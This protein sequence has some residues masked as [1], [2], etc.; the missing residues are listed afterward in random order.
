MRRTTIAAL[1]T[2]LALAGALIAP[3]G[4]VA[5]APAKVV[6]IVG[7]VGSVTASYKSDAD[8]IAAAALKYTPDVV[9]IYT[10]NATWDVVKA[11]LQGANVVV[12][13]GHGNGFPS[14]YRTSPW[15][16][17]QD[18]V[19]LNPAAG[20]GDTSV[21]YYGESYLANEVRLAPN[22]F[23][24]LVHLCYASGN[25]EP[26]RGD[27]TLA[28]AQQRIDNYGAG[29][30]AAG[31]RAVVAD[32]HYGSS[33]YMDALFTTGQTI[34]AV[35]RGAP[36]ARGNYGSFASTRTPGALAEYDPDTPTTG[37]YRSF[38]GDPTLTTAAVTGGTP[39]SLPAPFSAPS[40]PVVLPN[41]PTSGGG[42]ATQP[43][44]P[45]P[46]AP[47]PT[48]RPT[49]PAP[50]VPPVPGPASTPAVPRPFAVSITSPTMNNRAIVWGQSYIDIATTGTPGTNFRLE[51]ST[52]NQTW[53]PLKDPNGGVLTW[54]LDGTGSS[55]Y[56]YTPIRNYWYRA[57]AGGAVTDVART[58][59]RE[60]TTLLPS[61]VGPVA[62]G[63]AVTFS[64]IVRPAR[65]DLP[66]TTVTF[67]VALE[68]G[69]VW[70]PYA[71][72]PVAIDD[73]GVAR[74][75]WAFPAAGSWAVRA[76]A[77]PTA[78]NSNSFWTP[79]IGYRVP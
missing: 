22:A 43:T 41:P 61:A 48:A 34:E 55:T 73:A 30:L 70:L 71:S 44:S 60:T 65:A 52:D 31:A 8:A 23:V 4:L 7:P 57:V 53:T 47:A 29:F 68:S 12:Y 76:Q 79:Y 46:T 38:V 69:G 9:K 51:A 1:L 50:T 17:T 21:A 26:G 62:A 58:T 74:L 16:L 66:K 37:Y 45:A 39:G 63:T 64:A 36:A 13:L 54:T 56:R 28:V 75:A 25:S 5:A 3:A 78:V 10:P 15:P 42:P 27:P 19:G 59:V 32:A 20:G 11:A 67:Q 24:L 40:P 35:W 2:L 33:Y 72:F 49:S 77:A 18:G 6:V 14:P